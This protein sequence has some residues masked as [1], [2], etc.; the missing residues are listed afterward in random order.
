MSRG[1]VEA[2]LRA[3]GAAVQAVDEVMNRSGRRC[4]YQRSRLPG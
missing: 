3:A 4:D 1:T 2:A